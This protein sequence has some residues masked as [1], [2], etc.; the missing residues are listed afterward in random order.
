[1]K[2]KNN[3]EKETKRN[4]DILDYDNIDDIFDNICEYDY[5]E[6]DEGTELIK[7]F[8][9][10]EKATHEKD[11]KK[12]KKIAEKVYEECPRCFDALLY[13]ASLEEKGIILEKILKD[14]L[15]KEK[16]RLEK[17]DLFRKEFIGNFFQIDETSQ[18]I[19]GLFMLGQLY[20][21][22]GKIM[23]AK[24]IFLEMLKLDKTDRCKIHNN[25]LA[26]YVYLEDEDSAQ[27]FLKQYPNKDFQIYMSLFILYYKKNNDKK[28]M[29][30]LK[31]CIEKNYH[32]INFSKRNFEI[33][34][35]ELDMPED[36][37]KG[38]MSEI[39]TYFSSNM[40]LIN[41]VPLLSEYIV[42]KVKEIKK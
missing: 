8:A 1:M 4:F 2:R 9:E 14:G 39:I 40:F 5:N 12:S 35:K 32:L 6:L 11:V 37:K 27:K 38:T 36:L 28:A 17:E 13:R 20:S 10:L 30:Y 29:E 15:K 23:L 26:I 22:E 18:Y 3:K 41:S 31:K 7:A 19:K 16:E 21:A 42:E 25:L 33:K 34:D 24:E